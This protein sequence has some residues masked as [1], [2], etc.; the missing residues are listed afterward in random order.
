MN[1][2]GQSI[3]VIGMSHVNAI[4]GSLDG[5]EDQDI[6]VTNLN[7]SPHIFDRR[8]NEI[9][10]SGFGD[11]Q[12]NYIFLSLHGNFH[13]VISLIENPV[14]FS[15]GDTEQGH[16]PGDDAI[17]RVFIPEDMMRAFVEAELQATTFIHFPKL[18]AHFAAAKI[19]HLCAPPPSGDQA[20]I[21]NFPGVFK[22]QLHLRVSPL[23]LRLKLYRIQCELFRQACDQHG[24]SF[25]DVPDAALSDSGALK[26][27]YWNDDPTHGNLQYG[28]LVIDQM[29]A[30]AEVS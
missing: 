27:D 7:K 6:Q 20:H 26:R 5:D 13:N 19:F 22:D 9:D 14:P 11:V 16:V 3:L 23:P 2:T 21:R 29:K 1:V 4:C 30:I 10:C 15:V 8:R 28:R 12:P 17:D 18:V 24:I 25:V